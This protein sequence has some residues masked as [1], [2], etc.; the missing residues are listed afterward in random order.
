MTYADAPIDSTDARERREAEDHAQATELADRR[1]HAERC[2][3]GW[4]GEDDEGRPIACPRCRP[5]ARHI[6]CRTCGQS[7]T[8]CSTKRASRLGRCCDHCDHTHARRLERTGS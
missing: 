5:H 3:A 8:A 7:P 1:D 2:R 4:L 6:D